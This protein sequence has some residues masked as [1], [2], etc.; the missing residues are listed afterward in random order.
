MIQSVVEGIVTIDDQGRVTSVESGCG[1]NHWLEKRRCPAECRSIGSFPPVEGAEGL[2]TTS[3][4]SVGWSGKRVNVK[5]D[6]G[7]M[8]LLLAVTSAPCALSKRQGEPDGF[9]LAGHQR[10]RGSPAL[11]FL[12]PGEYLSPPNLRTPLTALNASV[13][14]LLEDIETLSLAEIAELLNSVHLSVA[15]PA[16]R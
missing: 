12:F 4:H 14:L 15:G 3:F 7:G 6:K 2:F 5:T 16:G 1:T 11:A 13:E 8:M 9:G 10:G